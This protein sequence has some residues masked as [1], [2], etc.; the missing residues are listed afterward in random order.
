[1][2]LCP[3]KNIMDSLSFFSQ[4]DSGGP[5]TVLDVKNPKSSRHVIVGINDSILNPADCTTVSSV[6]V[7]S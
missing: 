7:S 6:D 1:M 4:G 5:L 3:M 2:I